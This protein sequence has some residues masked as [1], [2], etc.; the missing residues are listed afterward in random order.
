MLTYR[1][2]AGWMAKVTTIVPII[3]S[4]RAMASKDKNIQRG[5]YGQQKSPPQNLKNTY[6]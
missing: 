3:A 4:K 1:C 2:S 6:L 5:E